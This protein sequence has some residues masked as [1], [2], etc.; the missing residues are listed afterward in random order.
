M[1]CLRSVHQ[2]DSG[3]GG[4]RDENSPISPPLDPHLI[5]PCNHIPVHINADV[6]FIDQERIH[7]ETYQFLAEVTSIVN[8]LVSVK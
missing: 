1:R 8:E 5:S 7:H 4:G 2:H 3:K 6:F